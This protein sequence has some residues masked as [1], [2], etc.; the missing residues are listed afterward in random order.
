M[1]TGLSSTYGVR[2]AETPSIQRSAC[3]RVHDLRL[4]A[5]EVAEGMQQACEESGDGWK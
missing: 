2:V 3:D 5:A 1:L 4:P